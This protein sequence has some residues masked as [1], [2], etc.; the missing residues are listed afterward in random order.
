MLTNS[1]LY[2]FSLNILLVFVLFLPTESLS[3]RKRRT[4]SG[5]SGKEPVRLVE[6]VSLYL[7]QKGIANKISFGEKRDAGFSVDIFLK[8]SEDYLAKDIT[9]GLKSMF[10]RS[11]ANIQPAKNIGLPDGIE[12][13][14]KHLIF[15]KRKK[16][17]VL[18]FNR[19]YSGYVTIIIDDFGNSLNYFRL[20]EKIKEP[21]DC[22]VLPHL[23]YSKESAVKL[24]SMG[25]E[26]MLHCPM[27]PESIAIDAGKGVILS[28]MNE[29]EIRRTL[30]ENLES[31]PFAAGINNHM[32]SKACMA[33]NLIRTVL[34]QTDEKGLFFA[35][36]LTSS[37]SVICQV[38]EEIGCPVIKRDIFLDNV[39]EDKAI[40]DAFENLIKLSKKKG[41]AVGIGHYREQTLKI[42]ISYLDVIKY[43]DLKIVPASEMVTIGDGY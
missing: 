28:D 7:R 18:R 42:L 8:P 4:L 11:G 2:R 20:L 10:G 23:R 36:S 14:E 27:E 32:G 33:K 35:D 13:F 29:Q 38:A 43:N 9:D 41:R 34:K 15:I 30:E 37:S 40:R 31:V 26:V 12:C 39:K 3:A 22:A 21:V 24:N 25:F 6:E 17:G 1:V 19:V 5:P 16:T